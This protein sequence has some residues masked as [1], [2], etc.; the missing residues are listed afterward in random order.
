MTQLSYGGFD[1]DENEANASISRQGIVSDDG[2]VW[3]YTESW[4]IDGILHGDTDN[5]LV[6]AM[7]ALQAAYAIQGQD[8][9][10]TKGGTAMHSLINANSLS[11]VRITSPPQFAVKAS[12]ELT[13]FR[14]YSLVV[15]A[16]FALSNMTYALADGATPASNSEII[17][18]KYEEL[19]DYKGTGGPRFALL[20]TITGTYLKQQLTE[21]SPVEVTQSGMA[22]GL[23]KRPLPATPIYPDDEHV[24]RRII[25]MPQAR[26]RGGY[27]IE[28]P[29]HWSYTF[30]RNKPFS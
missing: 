14:S 30:E 23:G 28:F 1:H 9:V 21:T 4:A 22:I 29:I 18:L 8:L 5:E 2:V 26:K 27:Q 12:G 11:G 16:D 3:A 17:L 10:L 6:T 7:V 24:E 19:F 20:P 13:T 25:R 15:E